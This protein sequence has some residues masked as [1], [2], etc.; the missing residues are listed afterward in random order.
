MNI[1]TFVN[2]V[3]SVMHPVWVSAYFQVPA[4]FALIILLV[5]VVRR[6][7]GRGSS[8]TAAG[9]GGFSFLHPAG[10]GTDSG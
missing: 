2:N 4:V 5:C 1:L 9:P 6:E 3:I 10:C 7:Q 8:E